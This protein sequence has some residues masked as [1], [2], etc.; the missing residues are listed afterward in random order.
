MK[1]I[2]LG[3]FISTFVLSCND[4]KKEEPATATT[5]ATGAAEAKKPASEVLDPSESD[6]VKNAF[7]AFAKGDWAGTAASYDDNVRHYTGAGDSLIGKQAVI[8]SYKAL[9]QVI[10]SISFSPVIAMPVRVN[11]SQSQYD[12][13]GKWV[14]SWA[15]IHVKYKN[16]KKLNMWMH[17]DFHYGDN[18]KIDQVIQYLD[19]VPIREATKDLMKK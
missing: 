17:Q 9:W 15:F 11:E 14:F 6:A 12:R 4:A 2:L 3:V 1:K 10:D 13:T 5:P 16:A 19:Q 18:G 7:A 8:D